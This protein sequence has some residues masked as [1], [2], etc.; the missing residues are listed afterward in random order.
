MPIN[1]RSESDLA[2]VLRTELLLTLCAL[3]SFACPGLQSF[4]SKIPVHGLLS[5]RRLVDEVRA[6]GGAVSHEG[7]LD[8]GE[9]VTR[10]PGRAPALDDWAVSHP[11]AYI[12]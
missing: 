2:R 9:S 1:G 6:R 4:P 8:G 3:T 11:S 7:V 5:S 12:P 10:R